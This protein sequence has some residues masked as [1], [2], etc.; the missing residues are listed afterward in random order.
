MD[1]VDTDYDPDEPTTAKNMHKWPIP[2]PPLPSHTFGDGPSTTT[3]MVRDMCVS[4]H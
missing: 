4:G 1:K 3:T 2:P